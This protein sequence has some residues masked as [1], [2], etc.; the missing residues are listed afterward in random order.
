MALVLKAL[1]PWAALL[2]FSAARTLSAQPMP[3]KVEV[4]PLSGEKLPRL[5]VGAVGIGN[6]FANVALREMK[7]AANLTVTVFGPWERSAEHL[8]KQQ[9]AEAGVNCLQPLQSYGPE[10]GHYPVVRQYRGFLVTTSVTTIDGTFRLP[11]PAAAFDAPS[12]PLP[13]LAALLPSASPS[14]APAHSFDED[15]HATVRAPTPEDARMPWVIGPHVME[16]EV[17]LDTGRMTPHDW[18][19]VRRDIQEHFPPAEYERLRGAR[20]RKEVVS[21]DLLRQKVLPAAY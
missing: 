19:D 4:A 17:V 3:P 20:L 12:P 7:E 18:E 11:A 21:I 1:L 16:H 5:P 14:T 15:R 10:D 9:A 6:C 13:S 2:A 8:A